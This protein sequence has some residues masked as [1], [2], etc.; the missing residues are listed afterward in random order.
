MKTLAVL[1]T[2]ISLY[3]LLG[4][5]VSAQTTIMDELNG[6][7]LG[8]AHG[9]TYGPT[10]S[11]QGAIFTRVSDSRIEYSFDEG[12]PRQGTLE[13]W[14]KINAGYNYIDYALYDSSDNAMLFST[15]VR[16]GDVNWPGATQLIVY[17]DGRIQYS[18][19]NAYAQHDYHVLL[20]D[21]TRFR[22]NEWYAVGISFGSQ[23]KYIMIDGAIVASDPNYT[24]EMG[25]AGN[26]SA[27]VD[28]PTIGQT[29]SGFWDYHQY[30]GGFYGVIDRFRASASQK[31]WVLALG[32]QYP[33]LY[34]SPDS[35]RQLEVMFVVTGNNYT[36]NGVVKRYIKQPLDANF[37]QINS[38]TSD[39]S[40]NIR[41]EYSPK[42]DHP[43]G[44]TRI[45]CVDS[46]TGS[47]SNE[48]IEKVLANNDCQSFQYPVVTPAS[49][50]NGFTAFNRAGNHMYH[51]GI[52]FGG[53]RKDI[54]Q[55][56]IIDNDSI[57]VSSGEPIGLM[58][59]SE[60]E[61]RNNFNIHVHFE[62]KENGALGNRFDD[63]DGTKT[64]YWG[65]TPDLPIKYGYVDP[66]NFIYSLPNQFS[67]TTGIKIIGEEGGS[68]KPD[69]G[70]RVYT[71]PGTKYSVL[72]WTGLDQFFV[73][74]DT[75]FSNL[76]SDDITRKWYKIYLPNRIGGI[77]GWVASKKKDG[78]PLILEQSAYI[79]K[80]SN[81][82]NN[83]GWQLR[84]EPSDI[85]TVKIWDNTYS[86]Y[87]AVRVWKDQKF[88]Q[89]SSQIISGHTWHGIYVPKLYYQNP[90]TTIDF[91]PPQDNVIGEIESVWVHQDAITFTEQLVST[92]PEEYCLYQNYPN[93]FNPTTTI[94]YTIPAT[95]FVALKIYDLLGREIETLV[96]D[97]KQPGYYEVI[98]NTTN[99]SS[100]TVSSGVYFYRLQVGNF[101]QTKKLIL[102]R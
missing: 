45:Y 4:Y 35:G 96:E 102:L 52:D 2:V 32:T 86:R 36:P 6:T 22:F 5:R 18:T 88:V 24:Q 54:Y 50:N 8:T 9:I 66:F 26:F 94:K 71:G 61:N 80:I 21:S 65:Y 73:T 11:G 10:L 76:I 77:F 91:A 7:T 49:W 33:T 98:F 70:I 30:D 63:D 3:S 67:Y 42:C 16:G 64:N 47:Q 90:K 28:K 92:I 39:A 78:T 34:V 57:Y 55:R 99:I 1:I 93:P 82:N 48:I 19:G 25:S 58:G 79:A 27:P 56:I 83:N 37:R 38:I 17:A 84:L 87:E 72:G 44:D 43:V 101:I 89:F 74:S 81:D 100:K 23:G 69:R 40:G 85:N 53:N 75:A 68:S 41:W 51:T 14:A 46:I 62:I 59:F 97:I 12:I 15:D 95:S 20:A 31:D 60:N 29:V 13:W